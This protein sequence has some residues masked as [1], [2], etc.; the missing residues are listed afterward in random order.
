MFFFTLK[1]NKPAKGSI[2]KELLDACTLTDFHEENLHG[3]ANFAEG[4]K[5]CSLK[6]E[7]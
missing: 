1:Q 7:H 5:I 6:T 3:G 4:E 2:S